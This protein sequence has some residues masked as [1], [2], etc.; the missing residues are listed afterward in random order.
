MFQHR[1][2]LCQLWHSDIIFISLFI[3]FPTPPPNISAAAKYGSQLSESVRDATVASLAATC[4]K[5]LCFRLTHHLRL[6]QQEG[7]GG[8]GGGG[9][10]TLRRSSVQ[11][12]GG[13]SAVGGDCCVT[14]DAKQV[15][16][17]NGSTQLRKHNTSH[18]DGR[19]CFYVIKPSD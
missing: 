13:E 5:L 9:A 4:H 17:Q 2:Q 3:Y 14:H 16:C 10:V 6:L 12:R 15:Y 8:R 11:R 19:T 1:P 18:D 7:W